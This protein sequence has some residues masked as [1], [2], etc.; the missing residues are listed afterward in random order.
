M[1]FVTTVVASGRRVTFC[2]A[3]VHKFTRAEAD[4]IERDEMHPRFPTQ[5]S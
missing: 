3:G 4:R 5:R 2:I 1:H